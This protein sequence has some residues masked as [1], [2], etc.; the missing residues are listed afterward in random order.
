MQ[1]ASWDRAASQYDE[2]IFD[3]FANDRNRVVTS[4]LDRLIAPQHTVCDFGCGVGRSVPF[5]AQR[6]QHVWAVDFSA[7]SLK[8]AT[9]A[10]KQPA[11]VQYLKRDLARKGHKFCSADV[12][13]LMQVL[14][15][16]ESRTRE[17]ILA[18]VARNLRRGGHLIAI[19]PSLEVVLLTYC[20]I[21]EWLVREGDERRDAISDAADCARDEIVSLVDG[22]VKIGDT[23]TKHYLK[24]EATMMFRDAGFTLIDVQKVEYAW[25]EDF[26]NAPA[27]MQEP[28]PWDWMLVARKQ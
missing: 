23:P 24:E 28:H 27:W 16:P 4:A 11:N 12:G 22:I 21:V 20:R 18:S 14:I 3:T 6:A 7:K 19:V 1:E 17:G 8:V 13:L 9:T 2:E 25:N 5:L 10:Q 26:E 15:M